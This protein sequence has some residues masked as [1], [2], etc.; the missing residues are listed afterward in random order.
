M[1]CGVIDLGNDKLWDNF[2]DIIYKKTNPVS[3]NTWFNNISL[4]NIID[5]KLTIKVPMDIHKKILS[6]N[7]YS[8][9]EDAFMSL[10]GINYDINFVLEDEI[11]EDT[12]KDLTVIDKKEEEKWESN[13]I[14]SYTF[15]NFV[16]GDTNRFAKTAAMAV[17][18]QPGKI[19]NPLFIY[20]KSGL[21]KTHL[22]HAI[23]NQITKTSNLKVLYTTSDMF[24]NDFTGIAKVNDDGNSLEYAST[25]KDK[26]RNVDVL[27]IDDIQYLVGAEKTQQ[28]FFHTFNSLHQANKQIII[29]SDRSPDDLKKLEERLRSRFTWGLPVDIYPPDFDLRCR[30][31][32]NKIKNL[33]I[34]ILIEDDVI[35]YIANSCDNDVR[36]LEGAITRLC[37]YA[38]MTIPQK[39]DMEFANEA[40]KDY[41]T[42]NIYSNGDIPSI[43]SAVCDFYGITVD[44]IKSKKRSNKIAYPRQ[45]AMYLSR[46]LTDES[47]PR[48]GLE[49][50][51]R[52][53]S[54]VIH[55]CDKI[56]DDLKTSNELK[57]AI[58]KIKNKINC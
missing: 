8:L 43:Q 31:L 56:E 5:N 50:G 29:S 21:G 40:L 25:F 11:K 48:I 33:D 13:L 45:V 6:N 51:G 37:A 26:Y 41:I 47:F 34:A 19:Y 10:T 7:Y 24:M 52:D 3:F 28:E 42:K 2:L 54:T 15:D 44:E 27:I 18:E 4:L 53:H 32:K 38:A 17:T 9:I 20:G 58:N 14:D 1:Y 16:V 49:F 12:F 55:A 36:Y 23:G 30:I 46:M 39:I 22:M 35:E 57:E